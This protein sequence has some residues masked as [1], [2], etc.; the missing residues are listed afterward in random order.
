MSELAHQCVFELHGHCAY[1]CNCNSLANMLWICKPAV[2]GDTFRLHPGLE[3]MLHPN[4][5]LRVAA[6][7]QRM[8]GSACAC[9]QSDPGIR[10]LFTEWLN[11]ECINGNSWPRWNCEDAQHDVGLCILSTFRRNLF[12][13]WFYKEMIYLFFPIVVNHSCG[14][15]PSRFVARL[16]HCKL[17]ITCLAT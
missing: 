15:N 10:C 16:W 2:I 6:C 9:A 8:P 12:A 13:C 7:E 5:C 11:T 14:F 1:K 3:Y 4:R 17:S